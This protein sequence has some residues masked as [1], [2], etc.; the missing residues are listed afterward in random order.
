MIGDAPGSAW[1]TLREPP[2]HSAALHL[3]AVRAL[4]GRT[5]AALF[6]THAVNAL[7]SEVRATP[8]VDV[9]A[10]RPAEVAAAVVDAVRMRC[11]VTLAITEG[12]NGLVL[13]RPDGTRGRHVADVRP[14]DRLPPVRRI[15]RVLVVAPA[16]LIAGKLAV[17][18]ARAG[19]PRSY[20][21]HRDIYALL[22]TFPDL[23]I[24]TGPVRDRLIANGA[25]DDVLSAWSDWVTREIEPDG[26]DDDMA[27]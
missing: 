20:T 17:A 5:D 13:N 18:A 27:W 24:E 15:E 12:R 26:E 2:P 7:V 6:G 10:A 11:G 3:A 21:D 4:K 14:V 1:E 16:E 23:K 8:D 9:L 22:L 19:R 25:S